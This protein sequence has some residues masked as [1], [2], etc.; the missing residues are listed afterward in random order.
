M[1]IIITNIYPVLSDWQWYHYT[2]KDRKFQ[3]Y[4][5]PAKGRDLEMMNRAW[6]GYKN[7]NHPTDIVIYRTFAINPLKFWQW[8][9]Y[10]TNP[11]YQYP[12]VSIENK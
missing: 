7:M 2:T 6:E 4:E 3:F 8:R 9:D 10:F 5:F 1:L 12:Y 11:R